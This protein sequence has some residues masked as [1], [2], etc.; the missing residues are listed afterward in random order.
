MT[1]SQSSNISPLPSQ[2]IAA[3]RQVVGDRALLLHEPEF[4]G[5]EK[6]YLYECIDSTYVSSVGKFVDQFESELVSF[7][8]SKYAIAVVSGTAALHICLKLAGVLPGDE[9]LMPALTFIATANA[10]RYCD[11]TPH[12][13]DVTERDL[14]IDVAALREYLGRITEFRGGQCSI[15]KLVEL[16]ER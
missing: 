12:F 8:G 6:D 11:A 2:I 1:A 14:G 3:I 10:V 4:R 7:T 13:V 5:R 9:V 16:S 15:C